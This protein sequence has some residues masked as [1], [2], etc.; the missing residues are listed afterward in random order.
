MAKAIMIAPAKI[1]F[2][3]LIKSSYIVANT[4]IMKAMPN[5]IHKL[6]IYFLPY[7]SKVGHPQKMKLLHHLCSFR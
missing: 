4:Q 1:A 6:F 2:D 5:S 3:I 7:S